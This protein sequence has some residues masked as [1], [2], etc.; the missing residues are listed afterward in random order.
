MSPS[1]GSRFFSVLADSYTIAGLFR[2]RSIHFF[3]AHGR[4]RIFHG[5]ARVEKAPREKASHRSAILSLP[6]IISV[7]LSIL[8]DS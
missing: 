7:V 1:S 4:I 2:D 6:F 8:A 5:A 3:D